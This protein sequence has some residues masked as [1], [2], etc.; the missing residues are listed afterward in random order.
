MD[1]ECGGPRGGG[2]GRLISQRVRFTLTHK[3][4]R[5]QP[6]LNNPPGKGKLVSARAVVHSDVAGGQEGSSPVKK[7]K[8]D[9]YS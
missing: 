5:A 3:G 2:R 8:K 7:K 6:P 1:H 4:I 9:S